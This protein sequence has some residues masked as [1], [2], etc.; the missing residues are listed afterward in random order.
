MTRPELA[1]KARTILAD[2]F[3]KWLIRSGITGF[4]ISIVF[5]FTPLLDQISKVWNSPDAMTEVIET[6]EE[7]IRDLKII[8]EDLREATGENRVI[9]QPLGQSYIEEPVA[10]GENVIMILL[11]E[12]T[13]LGSICLLTDWVPLFADYTNVII[14]GE[15]AQQG[16]IRRQIGSSIERLRMEMIPPSILQPGRIEV[17]LSLEYSCDGE[18]VF[19]RTAVL[20]YTLLPGE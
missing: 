18:T 2:E 8:A 1:T 9:R 10:V 14:P 3:I 6:Q 7:I 13:K 11:T 15:K 12:R 4:A 19:D 20:A 17:Y 5:L 16:T